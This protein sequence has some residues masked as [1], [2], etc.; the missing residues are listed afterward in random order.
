MNLGVHIA[1]LCLVSCATVSCFG[2]PHGEPWIYYTNVHDT[3]RL[4]ISAHGG[5]LAE[6]YAKSFPDV[7]ARDETVRLPAEVVQELIEVS[8]PEFVGVYD[9][10]DFRC[11]ETCDF[12]VQIDGYSFLF[13]RGQDHSDETERLIEAVLVAHT[14]EAPPVDP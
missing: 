1:L 13:D 2:H 8:N 6:R 12:Y 4:T 3:H 11:V 7:R 5:D 10:D 9:A 14:V